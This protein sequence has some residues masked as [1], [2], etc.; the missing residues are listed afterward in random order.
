MLTRIRNAQ[1]AGH[2]DVTMPSSKTKVGIAKVM[3][4]EG[5]IGQ[6]E[7][8]DDVKPVLRISLKYYEGKPVIEEM[9]RISTPG[10][11]QYRN[12]DGLPRVKGGLGIAIVSTSNG[13]MTDSAARQ[14]GHGGE[15][16]CYIA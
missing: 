2:V 4:E 1:L 9:K 15:I 12:K 14:S 5:Y 8:S 16:L 13:I 7:V 3:Q 10:L 11:R 6:F